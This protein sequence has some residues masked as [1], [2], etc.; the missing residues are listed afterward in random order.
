MICMLRDH[1]VGLRVVG[2]EEVPGG[3]DERAVLGR[4]DAERESSTTSAGDVKDEL[5]ICGGLDGSQ[6][7]VYWF[8]TFC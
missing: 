2:T 1:R 8:G 6:D 7:K 4:N 3:S 5:H